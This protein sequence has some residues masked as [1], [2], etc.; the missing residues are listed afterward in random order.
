MSRSYDPKKDYQALMDQAAAEGDYTTA[1]LYE[2]K[3]NAKI[4]GEGLEYG[5]SHVYEAYLPKNT[6]KEMEDIFKKIHERQ[7]FSYDFRTDKLYEQYRDFYSKRGKAAME[8]ARGQ[9]AALTGGYGN[10]YAETLA[11]QAYSEEMEALD[12]RVGEL[13]DRA[14]E[15]YD[16]EGK[17]LEAQYDR[18]SRE[19]ERRSG[20]ARDLDEQE[21][22]EKRDEEEKAY[23]LALKMLSQGLMPSKKVLEQSG[24]THED[25]KAMYDANRPTS[26]YSSGSG[27]GSGSGGSS[28]SGGGSG[29]GSSSGSGSGSGSGSTSGSGSSSG[30]GGKGSN[31]YSGSGNQNNSSST[32]SSTTGSSSTGSS[33]TGSS[34]AGGKTLSN[35]LWDKLRNAYNAGKKAGDLTEFHSYRSGLK[36]QGYDVSVF[37]LWAGKTYGSSYDSGE[38]KQIDRQSVLNLGY[39]PLSDHQL[40]LLIAQGLVEEYPHGNYLRYRRTTKT[41]TTPAPTP[42]H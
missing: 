6:A 8:D 37:D 19:L 15:A 16:R 17:A 3:R 29:K 7:P 21:A 41:P 13:Y 14:L 34:A 27:G 20:L 36:A 11:K 10:S 39:G 31:K 42:Y 22:A 23:A 4:Q 33:A 18:A 12:D 28:G 35:S 38:P 40:R 25:A 32:G 1:A 9:A 26:S 2:E 5:Q 30:S 24:L